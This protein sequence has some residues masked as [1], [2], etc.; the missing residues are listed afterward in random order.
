[1]DTTIRATTTSMH[2][3]HLAMTSTATTADLDSDLD[4]LLCSLPFLSAGTQTIGY[5]VRLRMRHILRDVAE[6]AY[7]RPQF[8]ADV[9]PPPLLVGAKG[10]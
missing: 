7:E 4:P 9:P 3:K 5:R 1:M 8:F 10:D 2:P 6:L